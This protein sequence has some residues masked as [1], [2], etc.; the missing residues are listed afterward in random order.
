MNKVVESILQSIRKN[1]YPDKKVNLPFKAIFDACKKHEIKLS[2]VLKLL[3]E[4]SVYSQI[5]N[6][7]ILFFSEKSDAGFSSGENSD[8][9]MFKAAMDQLNKMDPEEVEKMKEKVMNM[10]EA[11]RAALME[12]AKNYF[13]K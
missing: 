7:K 3:E 13:N 2:E 11:E 10:S 8:N 1:G 9:P 12:Q 5:G 6:E 4:K